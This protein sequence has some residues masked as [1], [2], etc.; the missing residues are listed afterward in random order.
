MWLICSCQEIIPDC[1][2]GVN[3]GFTDPML[4]PR[5]SACWIRYRCDLAGGHVVGAGVRVGGTRA[6]EVDVSTPDC[7]KSAI[8]GAEADS[9]PAVA[10]GDAPRPA[11]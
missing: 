5:C 3:L 10:D 11:A 4:R 7:C 9:P 1:A 2:V 8:A 6:V